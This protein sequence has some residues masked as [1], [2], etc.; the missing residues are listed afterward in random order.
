[1]TSARQTNMEILR[2]LSMFLVL[3]V[4]ANTAYQ[5][6]PIN[7]Q[8][9]LA[10]PLHC[11]IR[12]LIESLSIVCVNAFVLLSGW[13]GINFSLK[14]LF[15][16]L[17]Q[18]FFFSVILCLLPNHEG[19]KLLIDLLTLKHYWFV[20]AYIILFILSPA[21]NIFAENAPQKTFR[22]VLIAF[23]VMQTLFSFFFNS[24][25]FDDGFSPIPFIGL[26]LLSRYIRLYKPCF[27]SFKKEIDLCLYL[28]IAIVIAVL[29]II[30]F[31]LY[32]TGG[33]MFNYTN[34]I[35][36]AA[37]VYFVLFFS[38]IQ[39][40]YSPTILWLASSSV[41]AYLLHMHP[42]FFSS[43]YIHTL[44]SIFMWESTYQSCIMALFFIIAVFLAGVI[45]DKVRMLLWKGLLLLFNYNH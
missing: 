29:S 10:T 3:I 39:V 16:F 11:F 7:Q 21:L 2:L 25:W 37:S 13:F 38:K 43:L 24:G 19:K 40:N 28:G 6:W 34:P 42:C 14:K 27:S 44:Q 41:G 1:M 18:V 12:F 20:R 23:F 33:R 17:F 32:G 36:I 22:L 4:H 26:Y 35:V 8:T 15:S 5:P 31:K 9:V 30:L 45:I